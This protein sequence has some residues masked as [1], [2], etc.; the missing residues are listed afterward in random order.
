MMKP[1]FS[2][3]TRKELRAYLLTHRDDRD[4][5]YAYVDRSEVEAN[6]I[7]LPPV[8]SMDELK[9]FPEFFEKVRRNSTDT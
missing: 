9:N 5:F 8:Q 4:A 7:E 3:M 2:A 1:D 6:W